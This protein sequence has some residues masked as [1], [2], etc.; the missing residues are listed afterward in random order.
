MIIDPAV[1]LNIDVV[2]TF[3]LAAG[4][5]AVF[6]IVSTGGFSELLAPGLFEVMFNEIEGTP[7]SWVPAFNVRTS[8]RAYEEDF[9]MAGLG[10]M[11]PKPEGT[12]TSFDEPLKG[13][14]VRY[15]HSSY[16]LGFRITREMWDDDLYDIMQGMSAELGR[17]AAYRIE[18]DAWSVLNNAFNTAFAGQDTLP[19]CSTAHTR[20]DGGANIANRPSTDVDFSFTA[21]QAAR[22]HFKTLVDDRGRPID[23]S[24]A[25]VYLDP[26]FEWVARE[27]MESEYKPYTANN[28]INVVKTD[29]IQYQLV[30]YFTDAD[31]WFL[32]A[33]KRQ[34][35]RRGGHDMKFWWRVRPETA[36]SDDFLSGDALFKIYARYSKGFSEW[37]GIYGS[38]GG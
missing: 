6:G 1:L 8:K 34:K 11:I 17:A 10:S 23:L 38:T 19:L 31:Q 27:I 4:S 3:L 20:L 14:T 7:P 30:R 29:S 37:R 21:Y 36:N 16:G 25:V 24:P 9:K 15:T 35:G 22:D 26:T 13:A 28:E 12:A 33:P 2:L 18:V 5:I 32:A